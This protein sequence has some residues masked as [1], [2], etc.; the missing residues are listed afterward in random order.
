MRPEDIREFR[1][2]QPFKPF[3]IVFTDGKTFEIPH[4][5]F[6]FVTAHTVEIGVPAD[7]VS[8][9]PAQRVVASPLHVIR[10]ESAQ[11]ET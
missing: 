1:D 11:Q 9:M 2:R 7:P 8:G 4:W 5:D 6:L 3:R 10:V